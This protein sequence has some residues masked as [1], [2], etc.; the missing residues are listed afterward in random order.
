M[1]TET[2]STSDKVLKGN[3][4][5]RKILHLAELEL[6]NFQITVYLTH[7]DEPC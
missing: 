1:Y 2:L 6:G 4:L 3:I 5:I 7:D